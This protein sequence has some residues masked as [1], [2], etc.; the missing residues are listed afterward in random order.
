MRFQDK[1]CLVTGGS[2]GIGLASCLRFA[3]EGGKVVIASR[4]EREGN[5]A[6]EQIKQLGGEALFVKTDIGVPEQI[7][8]C[9]NTAV[10]KFGKIDVLVNNAAMMTFKPIVDLSLEEW[11]SVINVNLRSVF[12]FCKYCI[13]HMKNGAVVNISSVHGHQTTPNVLSYA[14]SKGGLEAFTRGLALE[15]K[16]EQA[17]FNAV[18]P[19]AVDTP[20]LWSNPNV[21]NGTEKIEG[22]IGKPEELAAAI[23]FLA[24]SEASYINGTTLVVDGGRLDIL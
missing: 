11:E 6:V 20:M 22:A 5:E 9:V 19:G 15:Y 10:E 12:L 4:S 2:S 3:A 14:A 13:P 17:R 18:A 24:S 16:P 23:C 1:V 8:Q 7:E 21:K